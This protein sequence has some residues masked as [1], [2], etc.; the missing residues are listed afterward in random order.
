MLRHCVHLE[1]VFHDLQDRYGNDDPI[2]LQM[3]QELE[4][5]QVNVSRY[6]RQAVLYAERRLRIAPGRRLDHMLDSAS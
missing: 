5:R 4:A 6:P 2:V 1:G 3:K